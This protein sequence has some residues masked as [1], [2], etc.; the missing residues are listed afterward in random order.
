MPWNL[1]LGRGAWGAGSVKGKKV[2]VKIFQLCT[3]LCLM[4]EGGGRKGEKELEKKTFRNMAG[5]KHQEKEYP[6]GVSARL[7]PLLCLR[8]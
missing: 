3:C 7:S 2:D 4:S 1:W 6:Q 8:L 5:N